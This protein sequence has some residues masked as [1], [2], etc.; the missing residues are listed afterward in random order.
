MS[1][2]HVKELVNAIEYGPA[3]LVVGTEYS[4]RLYLQV[5]NVNASCAVSGVPCAWH[6]RKWRLSPHMT[7][8]EIVSTAFK[9]FLTA[10]E[11]EC[12]ERFRFKGQRIFG[13]HLD[14]HAL[15]HALESGALPESVRLPQA[16]DLVVQE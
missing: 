10:E 4:G 7:D 11:H 16:C 14:V 2:E 13:P 9:A 6:G 12:R 3:I 15:A 1:P 5:V 8:S